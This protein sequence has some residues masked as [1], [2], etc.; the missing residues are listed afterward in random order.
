MTMLDWSPLDAALKRLRS[1]RCPLPIWWRD[2]DAITFT[3]ALARLCDLSIKLDVPVHIAIVPAHAD[4][5]LVDF[6]AD[7]QQLIPVVHGWRHDNQ[8]PHGAKKSEFGTPRP[9]GAD[10]IAAAQNQMSHL[11]GAGCLPLF[12]PPWNRFDPSFLPALTR[13][14]FRGLS[15]FGARSARYAAPGILR[16]NTH[17]DPVDW[18]GTRGLK[19]EDKIITLAAALITARLEGVHDAEEPLGYLTHHL[20]HDDALTRFSEYLLKR[21][22]DGG[23]TVTSF[24]DLMRTGT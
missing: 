2:D 12:V 19:D 10:E 8:A 20:I 3:P 9:D 4:A 24:A 1:D 15:T 22:L 18:H 16:L 17:I 13:A 7:Q 11:F 21:L 23:A 5:S 14:G 6:V